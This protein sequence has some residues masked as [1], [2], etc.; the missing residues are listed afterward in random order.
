VTITNCGALAP[1]CRLAKLIAV[2]LVVYSPRLIVP[3]P[4]TSAVISTVV[5]TPALNGPDEPTELPIAGELLYVMPV[6]VHVLFVTF[7]ML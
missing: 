7:P 6:S 1:D 2:T 3:L 5:Q 4:V